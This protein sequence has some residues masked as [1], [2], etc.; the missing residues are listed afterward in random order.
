MDSEDFDKLIISIFNDKSNTNNLLKN[1]PN[2]IHATNSIGETV[3]H[4]L[5]VENKLTEIKILLNFNAN[6]NTQNDFGDT[7][8]SEAA[9]LGYLGMCEFLIQNGADA[10]MKN[11]VGDTALSQAAL[12][13]H[14]QIVNLLLT[15]I[16]PTE[17]ITDYFSPITYH[18]LL[19]KNTQSA[20]IIT[21]WI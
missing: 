16:Q 4:Y 19:D 8:L 5:V 9:A 15:L 14:I 12:Q 7:P 21:A 3:F 1:E 10:K 17:R 2:L 13:N 18:F 6:I 11:K 20:E